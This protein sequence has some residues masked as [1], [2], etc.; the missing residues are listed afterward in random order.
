MPGSRITNL[1]GSEEVHNAMRVWAEFVQVM[2]PFTVQQYEQSFVYTDN[3]EG[4]GYGGTVDGL[5][6][7]DSCL[8][9]TSDAADE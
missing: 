5:I 3:F 9:Y 1:D 7:S 6:R 2:T 4:F 8:L